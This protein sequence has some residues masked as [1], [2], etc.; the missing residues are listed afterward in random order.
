MKWNCT[1]KNFFS[2]FLHSISHRTFAMGPS[3]SVLTTKL[4]INVAQ[5]SSL[6]TLF[7]FRILLKAPNTLQVSSRFRTRI[8]QWVDVLLCRLSLVRIQS[9]LRINIS[10]KLSALL[11][12]LHGC[13]PQVFF[14]QFFMMISFS[15]V[16][17]VRSFP[18][19][20]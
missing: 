11:N 8:P 10:L 20:G 15:G 13:I 18:V 5:N 19:I 3:L 4:I 7:H 2:S 1:L 9:Y 14:S 12:S 16:V 6:T 17:A